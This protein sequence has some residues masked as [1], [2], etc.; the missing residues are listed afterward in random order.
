MR[1]RLS[2]QKSIRVNPDETKFPSA[3]WANFTFSNAKFGFMKQ[4]LLFSALIILV[5]CG[6]GKK[7][8]GKGAKQGDGKSQGSYFTL[9]LQKKEYKAR[10]MEAMMMEEENTLKLTAAFDHFY[11][12]EIRISHYS[13]SSKYVAIDDNYNEGASTPELSI[14]L[15]LNDP[16]HASRP[17]ASSVDIE[18]FDEFAEV[19]E[20]NGII[21]GKFEGT[22]YPIFADHVAA[23][24]FEDTFISGEFSLPVKRSA[25]S[26][27][28]EKK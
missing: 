20:E 11:E 25:D 22:V 12:V 26:Q 27:R 6:G 3:L 13:G 17:S 16:K 23:F 4:W 19:K 21:T 1:N 15:S 2:K 28:L 24:G 10:S 8:A 9:K 7:E 18:N 5:S 14:S